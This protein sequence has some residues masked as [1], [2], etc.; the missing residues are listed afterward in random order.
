M[1]TPE[2]LRKPGPWPRRGPRGGPPPPPRFRATRR[3]ADG[4]DI[5]IL[6]G[7]P[8]RGGKIVL[9]RA[10]GVDCEFL[11]LDPVQSQL[12][13]DPDQDVEDRFCQRLLLLGAKWFDSQERAGH[14]FTMQE[15]YDV[16]SLT[17]EIKEIPRAT[18]M[19]RRWTSVGWPKD[20]GF[21]VAEYDTPMR[22]PREKILVPNDANRVLLA[23][24]MEEKCDILKSMGAKF[25]ATLD[26][27]DGVSC[28]NAWETKTEGEFGPLVKTQ[29]EEDEA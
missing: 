26:E 15:G 6:W 10:T 21:W 8:S 27:Y 2:H 19:E 28:L 4:E 5:A 17:H 24:S 23:R 16:H 12:R 1:R 25:Y 7:W 3:L 11:G 9:E 22:G 14:I 13:R 18:K 20:G 29:Y